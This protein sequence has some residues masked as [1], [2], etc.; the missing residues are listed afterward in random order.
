MV[1]LLHL[2]I[3]SSATSQCCTHSEQSALSWYRNHPLAALVK[4]TE[5]KEFLPDVR[6][7]VSVLLPLAANLSHSLRVAE[8]ELVN[9]LKPEG[10]RWSL[11]QREKRA[12]E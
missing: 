7:N 9:S 2:S 6:H 3:H 4:I 8:K 5:S 1:E 12:H 10:T 11:G